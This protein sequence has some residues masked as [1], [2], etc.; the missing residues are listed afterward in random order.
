MQHFFRTMHW[1]TFN[2][3]WH[4]ASLHKKDQSILSTK[5][6]NG[7]LLLFKPRVTRYFNYGDTINCDRV[8]LRLFRTTKPI[9]TKRDTMHSWANEIQGS[10]KKR[11]VLFRRDIYIYSSDIVKYVNDFVKIFS[12]FDYNRLLKGFF[13]LLILTCWLSL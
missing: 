4:I 9:S 3:T 10:L 2:Q 8:K 1:I 6:V 11:H 12:N 5:L 13:V 7:V